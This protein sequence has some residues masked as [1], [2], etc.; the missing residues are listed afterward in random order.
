MDSAIP[1]I[2][3]KL[4]KWR[5]EGE[6]VEILGSQIWYHDQGP[7]TDDAVF[8]VHGYTQNKLTRQHLSSMYI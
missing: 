2:P 4:A 1:P 5:S 3:N 6:T 8:V 7:K